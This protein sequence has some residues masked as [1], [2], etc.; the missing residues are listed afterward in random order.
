MQTLI[1]ALLILHGLIVAAQSSGS[2]KPPAGGLQN[3]TWVAWWPTNLGRSWLLS[4]LGL[5]RIPFTTVVLLLNLAGGIAIIAAGLSLLGI[6]IP[7]SSW[8]TLAVVGAAI[9]LFMLVVY[10]HPLYTV[11]IGAN[12]AIL[13]ALL[14][15]RWP[16]ESLVK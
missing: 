9:S 1:A 6:V 11:G 5:E 13:I 8:G 4:S 2:F 15:M 3:P 7:A 14:W 16:F 10:L 12:L